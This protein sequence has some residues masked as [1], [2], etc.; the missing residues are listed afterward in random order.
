MRSGHAVV[1]G[2]VQAGGVGTLCMVYA[3]FRHAAVCRAYGLL[4]Y[5]DDGEADA[6]S[7]YA[8]YLSPTYTRMEALASFLLQPAACRGHLVLLDS[9]CCNSI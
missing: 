7:S 3:E 1:D 4:H 9:G 6:G 5:A 8:L 2:A